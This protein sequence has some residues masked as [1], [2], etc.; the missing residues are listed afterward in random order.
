MHLVQLVLSYRKQIMFKTDLLLELCSRQEF[1]SVNVWLFES[2]KNGEQ[3]CLL[4]D[5]Y[6]QI[7]II[8]VI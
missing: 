7:H 5:Y 3:L 6:H 1:I 2:L 4:R 8:T